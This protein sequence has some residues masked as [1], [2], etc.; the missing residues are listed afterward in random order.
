MALTEAV[1][2]RSKSKEKV[3]ISDYDFKGHHAKWNAK[4]LSSCCNMLFTPYPLLEM[5]AVGKFNTSHWRCYTLHSPLGSE[6]CREGRLNRKKLEVGRRWN[7]KT[8]WRTCALWEATSRSAGQQ[9]PPPLMKPEGTLPCSQEPT[10][11]EVRC[12]ILSYGECVGPSHNLYPGGI[13]IIGCRRLLTRYIRRYHPH[14]RAVSCIRNRR[15]R[16]AMV[17]RNQLNTNK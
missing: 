11:S 10:K 14:P 4:L 9:I 8:L 2:G 13:P 1:S 7:N 16:R 17:R 6:V 5:A 15:M 3:K 12:N